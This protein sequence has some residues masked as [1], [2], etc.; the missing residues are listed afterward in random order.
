MSR[1]RISVVVPTFNQARF[2]GEALRSVCDQTVPDWEVLVINNHSEDETE[3]VVRSI[4]DR[5]IALTNFH[6]RGVIAASRNVGISKARGEWV[7]FL[8]SDDSWLPNYLERCM[9]L[10]DEA[11]VIGVTIAM[12][13]DGE[14]QKI[15]RAGPAHR[16]T[17]RYLLYNGPCLTPS[18]TIVRRE[19]L[20]KVGGFSEDP[21]FATG[22]DHDLWLKLAAQGARFQFVDDPL[23]RYRLHDSNSSRKVAQHM[24][25]GL[26]ILEAHFA[27]LDDKTLV[28]HVLYRR[29]RA[30]YFYGAGRAFQRM[31]VPASAL[32]LFGRSFVTFPFI[33]RLYIAGFA[34]LVGRNVGLRVPPGPV[35]SG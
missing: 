17:F 20:E 24:A 30:L 10:A 27:K 25:A 5:R 23:V 34:A 3:D 8:D 9:A 16:A 4:E 7:A 6:N 15:L 29:C 11:D 12:E 28:D 22:E 26:A 14:V 13:R 31:G 35:A 33:A 1:P 2:L 19:L 18:G 21:A 32:P